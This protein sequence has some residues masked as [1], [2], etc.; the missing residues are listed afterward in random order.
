MP[1]F[2]FHA[3]IKTIRPQ[4]SA[5]HLFCTLSHLGQTQFW[6]LHIIYSHLNKGKNYNYK[7][8]RFAFVALHL[9]IYED[10]VVDRHY[11]DCY[12]VIHNIS[13]RTFSLRFR[14]RVCYKYVMHV[15]LYKRKSNGTTILPDLK[16]I[17]LQSGSCSCLEVCS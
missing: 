5:I 7:Q 17:L 8:V 16:R 13:E 10:V 12:V 14:I 4:Y 11:L 3:C 2:G 9:V 1:I 15:N 6:P